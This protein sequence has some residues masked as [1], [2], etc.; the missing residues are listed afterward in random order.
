MHMLSTRLPTLVLLALSIV[1][2]PAHAQSP[3]PRRLAW[4]FHTSAFISGNSDQSDPA[5]YTVYSG[6]GLLAG[7]RR[8]LGNAFAL[9]LTMR[10]ESREV[11]VAQTG[12]PDLRLGSLELLP[13]NLLFQ[14]R[15]PI[16]GAVRPFIGA[17]LNVTAAWEKT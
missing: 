12:G 8:Q 14:W 7:I 13:V 15:P 9:E 4:T 11:D 2:I 16:G 3:P 5:G 10:T 17:G 6:I 1:A